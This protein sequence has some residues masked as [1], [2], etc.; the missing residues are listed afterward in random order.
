MAAATAAELAE[1]E[2]ETGAVEQG[3]KHDRN[4]FD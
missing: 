4:S 3:T 1:Q 2:V